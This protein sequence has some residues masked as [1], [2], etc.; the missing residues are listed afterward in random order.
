MA[1]KADRACSPHVEKCKKCQTPIGRIK[2]NGGEQTK[3][4]TEEEE[5]MTMISFFFH[6]RNPPP[7]I[8]TSG[9]KENV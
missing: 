6:F 7:G 4:E 9:K 2:H 3:K 5:E 8:R 1:T